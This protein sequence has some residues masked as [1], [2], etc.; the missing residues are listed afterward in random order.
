MTEAELAQLYE[1]RSDVANYCCRLIC[2]W[3]ETKDIHHAME[4][5]ATI[6]SLKG[7]ITM[8]DEQIEIY[9]LLHEKKEPAMKLVVNNE[10]LSSS[11]QRGNYDK[12]SI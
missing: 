7:H 9:T 3:V 11:E 5:T 4:L 6:E 10:N 12:S 2:E 8:M 1:E